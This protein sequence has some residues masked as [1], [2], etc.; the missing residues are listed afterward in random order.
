[1]A[2]K[3]D[4]SSGEGHAGRPHFS[5]VEIAKA[6]SWF[7][8][9]QGLA[10]KKNYDYAIESYIS[11][12]NFWPEAV[13]E[14]HKPCRA[15]ALFRGSK[16]ASFADGYKYKITDKDP[17][18][19]MLN[20]EMLLS[21]DPNNVG[22]MEAVFKNAAR[23]GFDQT[24]MWMGELLADAAVRETK[25][26]PERFILLR[27]VYEEVGDRNERDTPE[28]SIQAFERAVD[29]LS[30]LRALK[31][32]DMQV[33]T[34]LR[35]VAGKLTILKGRYS[36]ADSFRESVH[37][38]AGQ[39]ELHD[40]DRMFQSDERM[41]VLIAAA[42]KRYEADPTDRLAVNELAG[43][44]CRQE[45][46]KSEQEAI[47]LLRQAA[48]QTGEYRFKMQADDIRIRQLKRQ[49]KKIVASGDADAARKHKI[50]ILRLELNVF[51]ER[52]DHYPTDMRVRFQYGL[53]LF[54]AGKYD[55]AIPVLQE[56][57]SD[58]KAR[59]HCNLYIG[60]CFFEKGYH[61]QAVETLQEAIRT[62][63]SPDDDLGKEMH[64]RL[65]R[66]YEADGRVD[67]ALKTYGQLIQWDYNY[68][69]GEVRK[70]LDALK[71]GG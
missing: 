2:Q 36:T 64:Y 61:S 45:D 25:P 41:T 11:G 55:E 26:N 54:Q 29:A 4:N 50:E 16:K 48:E 39:K 60:R 15:A 6:R 51:K 18:K 66:A 33:S 57:R 69:N 59:T 67:D 14:G 47:V 19:A 23:A 5:D 8:K 52:C 40:K 35:D 24:V 34:D 71:A 49:A 70:R 9:G 56:A 1:M 27:K 44:L 37:D 46:A 63:E 12:L 38:T 32:N 21:K 42:R 58:P 28:L 22:Y 20:A 65:G 10:A 43:L 3:S 62:H 13:D 68:R 17:K 31:P 53:R 30:K 7:T